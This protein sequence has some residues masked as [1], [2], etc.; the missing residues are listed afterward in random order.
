MK[1]L[2]INWL[3]FSSLFWVFFGGKLM[4]T[5]VLSVKMQHDICDKLCECVRF[6]GTVFYP[7][8]KS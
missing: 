1:N 4:I 3:L 5:T 2:F 8:D 7:Y 6:T